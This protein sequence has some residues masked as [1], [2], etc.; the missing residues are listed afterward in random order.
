[1]LEQFRVKSEKTSDSNTLYQEQIQSL[2]EACRTKDIMITKLLEAIEN[3]SSNKNYNNCYTTTTNNCFNNDSETSRPNSTH[4]A[5]PHWDI[6]STS[7]DTTA[8]SD[9]ERSINIVPSI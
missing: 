1:M 9:N 7:P 6:L 4:L 3:L 5:P 2:K 8:A